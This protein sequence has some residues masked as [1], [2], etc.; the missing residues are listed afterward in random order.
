M[1]ALTSLEPSGWAPV[2]LTSRSYLVDQKYLPLMSGVTY[3]ALG[4]DGKLS[5]TLN[6]NYWL[7]E[8][9]RCTF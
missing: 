3:W 1:Y 5:S 6:Y 2:H 9:C 8:S 4:M 7:Y